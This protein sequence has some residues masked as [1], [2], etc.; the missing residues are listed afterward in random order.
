[1]AIIHQNGKVTTTTRAARRERRHA[2]KSQAR[3]TSGISCP[4]DLTFS[5]N[6]PTNSHIF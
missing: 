5:G 1:M 3:Q 6:L 2:R 4:N